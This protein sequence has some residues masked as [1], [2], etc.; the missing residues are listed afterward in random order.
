MLKTGQW[1]HKGQEDTLANNKK[2]L[3]QYPGR[4][5]KLRVWLTFVL[6]PWLD[7]AFLA[8]GDSTAAVSAD[9][10]EDDDEERER[11]TPPAGPPRR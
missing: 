1:Q 8:L 3:V 2:Y 10:D 5:S 4:P 6:E 9:R 11:A 7:L